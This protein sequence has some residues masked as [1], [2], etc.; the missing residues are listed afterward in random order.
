MIAHSWPHHQRGN[1]YVRMLFIQVARTILLHPTSW[2]KH[3]FGRGHSATHALQRPD[4]CARQQA[5][6]D[7]F[8]RAG[9]RT[10]LGAAHR[11]DG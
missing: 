4:G 2:A 5:G 1:R 9:A 6:A 10:Q 7:R 8:D 11:T 3:S